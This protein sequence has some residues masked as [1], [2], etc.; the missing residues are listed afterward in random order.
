MSNIIPNFWLDGQA[1]EMAKFYTAIFANSKTG[2]IARYTDAGKEI[3]GHNAGDV[4]TADFEIEGTK[5]I[6]LN[7]GP[8]FKINPSIS[9]FVRCSSEDELNELWQ[10]L[11]VGASIRMPLD[12]YTFSRRFGWL[13]DKFGVSWRIFLDEK[14]D[15]QKVSLALMFTQGQAGKAEEAMNFYTSVFPDSSIGT[16]S[17]YM[18]GQEPDKEG[19]IMYGELTVLG[20]HWAI[21]DSAL[22]RDYTFNEAVSLMVECETQ[23]EIDT[24]WEKLSAVPEAEVCGWLK[25]K[26]GVS[27]QIVPTAMGKMLKEGTPEQLEKLTAAYMQMKKFDIAEL[28]RVYSEAA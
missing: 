21:M 13:I 3:H 15:A 2:H 7:G 18:A 23:E 28:E 19:T 12:M 17:R 4:L 16:I 9:F 11:S 22:E 10:K 26:Y 6:A 24:Y 20:D 5:I 8:Q 14:G 1:E 27:W 25:D